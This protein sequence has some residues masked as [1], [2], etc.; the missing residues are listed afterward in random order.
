MVSKGPVSSAVVDVYELGGDGN[1][2]RKLATGNSDA[3]GEFTVNL[4][5]YQNQAQSPYLS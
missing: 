5:D 2:K 3:A 4:A 1:R